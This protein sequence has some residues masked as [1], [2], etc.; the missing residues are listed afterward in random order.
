MADKTW[1]TGLIGGLEPGEI[2]LSPYDPAWPKKFDEQANAIADALGA[3]ALRI[4]HIGSTAVPG[5]AAKPIIDV[6]VVVPDSADESKY[7]PQLEGAGYVLRVREPGWNE[8]RMLRTP[9]KD[10]HVHIY[11]AGCAEIERMLIFRDRLRSDPESR[12][13]YEQTKRALAARN[14]PDMDTY[15][16]AKSE[17]VER[18]L[19][20][21]GKDPQGEVS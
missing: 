20:S 4:E 2:K 1:K 14:W 5:L 3:T 12:N 18:I 19:G 10:V 11:S 7:L 13:R 21:I 15:A 17:V 6:L 16:S 9:G 8:H